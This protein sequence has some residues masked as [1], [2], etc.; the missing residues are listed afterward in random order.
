MAGGRTEVAAHVM[1]HAVLAGPRGLPAEGDVFYENR[2][3]GSFFLTD[4]ETMINWFAGVGLGGLMKRS[5]TT[6]GKPVFALINVD[7]PPSA[8]AGEV[9]AVLGELE[10]MVADE[11]SDLAIYASARVGEQVGCAA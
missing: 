11:A 3:D 6:P 8:R 4:P 2:G 7:L 1:G 10:R 5:L 9:R